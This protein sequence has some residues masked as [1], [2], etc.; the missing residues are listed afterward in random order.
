MTRSLVALTVA[1]M[2]TALY[3]QEPP[4]SPTQAETLAKW[5]WSISL[6]AVP[7]ARQSVE[8]KLAPLEGMEYK[9]RLGRGCGHALFVD[10]NGRGPLGAAQST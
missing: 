7:F 5:P 8:I 9:Y 6:Q 1:L 2:T 10:I 3:A 4:V